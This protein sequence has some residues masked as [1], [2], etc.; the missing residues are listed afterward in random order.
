SLTLF[1][2]V[3]GQPTSNAFTIKIPSDDSLGD[4][5]DLIKA[6]QSPDFD[7][8][9]ANK[10]TLWRVSIPI[11]NDNEESLFRLD[12]ISDKDKKKLGPTTRV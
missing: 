9:V 7:G 12:N 5:E 4:L 8:I 6:K 3:E 10:L 1:C 2:L 11:I